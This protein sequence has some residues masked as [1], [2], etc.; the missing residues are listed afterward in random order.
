MPVDRCKTG[1]Q[2]RWDGVTFEILHPDLP[3]EGNNGS[4][5]LQISAAGGRALLTG[6]IEKQAERRLLRDRKLS[7]VAL[8]VVPH[9][10][11]RTSSTPAFIDAL[12]PAHA[13]MTAGYLNHYGFPKPDVMARYR[14]RHVAVWVTGDEGAIMFGVGNEGVYPCLL[15][16]REAG[17]YWHRKPVRRWGNS[18]QNP[19]SSRLEKECPG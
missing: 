2:W 9:H 10:G 13:I 5:V 15:Y 16:R 14:Q 8:L 12:R 3:G 17:R 11:S 18:P 1:Q 19:V 4:C 6:D 7:P